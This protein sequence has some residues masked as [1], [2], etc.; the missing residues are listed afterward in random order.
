[1]GWFARIDRFASAHMVRSQ[2]ANY[3]CGLSSI[4]MVNFKVKKSLIASG[5]AAGASYPS[6]MGGFVGA[7]LAGAALNDA[8]RSEEEVRQV[9]QT[10]S[11]QNVDL[12]V[13]GAAWNQ[14]TAVL[15]AL[16][17]GTWVAVDTSGTGFVQAVV[18]ATGDGAPVIV[19]V[20][21]PGGAEHAMVVDETHAWNG[22]H[23]LCVCDPWDGE[24]RLLWGQAGQ[25]A[26]QYDASQQP[27]S[28]TF[29]GDRRSSA[30]SALGTFNSWIVRRRA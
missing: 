1:M 5:L 23:Y 29:W 17:L 15:S 13:Q 14:Y 27:I 20:N 10:V 25:A 9:Y 8:V 18:D 19:V 24:L 3:G 21:Y 26:P 22:G 30:N 7:T 2:D 12:N 28:L 11:G 16:R 4:A 6:I